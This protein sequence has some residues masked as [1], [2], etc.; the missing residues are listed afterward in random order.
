MGRGCREWDPSGLRFLAGSKDPAHPPHLGPQTSQMIPP[1][2]HSPPAPNG[3]SPGRGGPGVCLGGVGTSTLGASLKWGLFRPSPDPSPSQALEGG[4]PTSQVSPPA[5]CLRSVCSD[6]PPR[7]SLLL[8]DPS[9]PV[10][11]GFGN[12]IG[13][14]AGAFPVAAAQPGE[15][16]AGR[17]GSALGG[18]Y[19]RL[20]QGR[21]GDSLE[22]GGRTLRVPDIWFEDSRAGYPCFTLTTA[23]TPSA[24]C[25]APQLSMAME[26]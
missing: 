23:G 10:S 4:N 13:H 26:P 1:S 5:A 2:P 7:C 22:A 18:A 8:A 3:Y 15:V 14:G 25:P 12:G 24:P 16:G 9:C 21:T 17:A 20:P 6:T 19:P 11:S